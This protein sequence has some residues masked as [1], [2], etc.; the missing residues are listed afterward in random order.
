MAYIKN[1][2]SSVFS[3]RGSICVGRIRRSTERPYVATEEGRRGLMLALITEVAQSYLELVELDRRLAVARDSRDAFEATHF[4][5]Q[6]VWSDNCFALASH[7]RGSGAGRGG[8]IRSQLLERRPDI[9]E[10]QQNLRTASAKIGIANADLFPRFGLTTLLG[11]D[12]LRLA[13]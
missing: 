2:P 5:Q 10:A 9:R 12:S 13:R 8:G 4:V 6:T 11:R 3:L 1:S 7:A